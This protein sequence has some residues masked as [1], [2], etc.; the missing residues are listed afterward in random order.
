MRTAELDYALPP[1][2]V[3]QT[4]AERRDASRLLVY[5]RGTGAIEHRG[6]RRAA[7][8]AHSD[9]LV[10][11]NTSRVVPARLHA[12]RPTG[13]VVELLLLEPGRTAPGRPSP[14]PRAA[15]TTATSWRSPTGSA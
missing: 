15:C 7:R 6:L 8:P 4:P 12:R 10:V 13:G 2:L 1:E 14:G 11:A 5:R 3:A 9:D